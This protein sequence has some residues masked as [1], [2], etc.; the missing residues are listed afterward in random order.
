MPFLNLKSIQRDGGFRRDSLKWFTGKYSD[1]HVAKPKNIIM[2]VTDMTQERRLVARCARVPHNWHSKYILSMDLIKISTKDIML[3]DYFYSMLRFS[4][5][6][7]EIKIHANGANVLHLNPKSIENF[8]FLFPD[9]TIAK[10]YNDITSS[11]YNLI[12]LCEMQSDNL[13]QTRDLLLP[14]LISGELSVEN[15]EVKI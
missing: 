4:N 9:E 10:S 5:F 3:S 12:D 6:A 15:L 13:R 14:R 2:A 7:D 1:T 8:Q 11:I